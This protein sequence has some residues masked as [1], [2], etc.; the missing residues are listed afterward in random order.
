L[1]ATG[2]YGEDADFS[3]DVSGPPV[4]RAPDVEGGE[5]MRRRARSPLG[6]NGEGGPMNL[7]KRKRAFPAAL[8]AMGFL[9][10]ALLVPTAL[11]GS[12]ASVAFAP[13]SHDYGTIDAG[14]TA[15]QTFALTNT[16]GSATGTLSV[17]LS[18][19]SA[20]STTADT[21]TGVSLGPK[22]TCSVT[23]QY[24]PTDY[25][26]SDAGTL[27][28]SG[29]KPSAVAT[30]SLSAGSGPL[31]ISRL[32]CEFFGGTYTTGAGS[33][34][35]TCNGWVNYGHDNYYTNYYTLLGDCFYV[36]GGNGS[37]GSFPPNIPGAND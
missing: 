9:F 10:L 32:H 14:T 6:R 3:A 5:Q 35:W 7:L 20:F 23:V 19:S 21:C 16:G 29:E 13:S 18:G 27:N 36:D 15:S 31:N 30:A 25:G 11:G 37:G 1:G 24:A 17:S 34:L 33:T 22:K 2:E 28:A 12:A 4:V 26:S 8:S